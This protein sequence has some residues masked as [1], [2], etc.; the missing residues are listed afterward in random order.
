M[1]QKELNRENQLKRADILIHVL[2]TNKTALETA[3]DK[4]EEYLNSAAD[5]YESQLYS[6]HVAR[7]QKWIHIITNRID[8]YYEVR[9]DE[10]EAEELEFLH[11]GGYDLPSDVPGF[12]KGKFDFQQKII[13]DKPRVTKPKKPKQ[14]G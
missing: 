11:D 7:V 1:L 5:A 6:Y 14:T 13:K 8:L 4:Y 2:S 12:E 10:E 3:H 9:T